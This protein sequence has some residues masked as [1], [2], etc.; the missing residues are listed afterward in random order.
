[1]IDIALFERLDKKNSRARS[2]LVAAREKSA[3][4]PS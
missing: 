2:R 3:W 4:G 1:L